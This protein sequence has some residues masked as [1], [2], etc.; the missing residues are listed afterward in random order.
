MHTVRI[1]LPSRQSARIASL[2]LSLP[3]VSLVIFKAVHID[4]RQPEG[5]PRFHLLP[6]AS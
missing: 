6:A 3:Q 2:P 1:I 5:V 4:H